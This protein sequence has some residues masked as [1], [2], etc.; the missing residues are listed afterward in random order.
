MQLYSKKKRRY[1]TLYFKT[2]ERESKTD[3]VSSDIERE[4]LTYRITPSKPNEYNFQFVFE[5][6]H[7]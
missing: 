6:V 2:N 5:Y 7:P 4:I 3:K 1:F